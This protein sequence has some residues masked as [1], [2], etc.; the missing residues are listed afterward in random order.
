MF[1]NFI[2]ERENPAKAET[3]AHS[4]Y[5]SA[6]FLIHQE[7]FFNFWLN[8]FNVVLC[9]HIGLFDKTKISE[10]R[11]R[12]REI[13]MWVH[14]SHVPR[15]NRPALAVW[16]SN[17]F[18]CNFLPSLLLLCR[19]FFP[20]SFPSCALI[21]S[22]DLVQSPNSTD[23]KLGKVSVILPHTWYSSSNSF[24]HVLHSQSSVISFT[25]E[26]KVNHISYR[27]HTEL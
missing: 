17:S 23:G 12:C 13:E 24:H 25:S 14:R 9:L 15:T 3:V 21:S 26:P 1:E 20:L 10:L 5:K 19:S 11:E 7:H 27:V 4:T 22:T 18:C 8:I 16:S 2:E 6:V